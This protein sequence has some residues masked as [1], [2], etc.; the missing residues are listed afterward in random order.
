[1][2]ADDVREV[3]GSAP[4][5]SYEEHVE[6]NRSVLEES[7]DEGD[8]ERVEGVGESAVWAYGSTLQ[9][10]GRGGWSRS[11]AGSGARR[12]TATRARTSPDALSTSS[13]NGGRRP[14]D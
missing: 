2:T 3:T 10:W 11:R 4:A 14:L 1:L 13:E 8:Y 6:Q 9:T 5:M 12:S 7:F